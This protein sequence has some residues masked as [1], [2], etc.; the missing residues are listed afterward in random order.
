MRGRRR[1]VEPLATPRRYLAS[2]APVCRSSRGRRAAKLGE[3]PQTRATA[4]IR[5]VLRGAQLGTSLMHKRSARSP[6]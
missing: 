4:F 3:R 5:P 6:Q 1:G 2:C